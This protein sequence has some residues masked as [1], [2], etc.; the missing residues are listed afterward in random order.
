[1]TYFPNYLY[2]HAPTFES[3]ALPRY[4]ANVRLP[5]VAPVALPGRHTAGRAERGG[6][7]TCVPSP[8]PPAALR[9]AVPRERVSD[10]TYD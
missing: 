4:P 10:H 9:L 3:N 1:M 7:R 8:R 6:R 5:G 2:S